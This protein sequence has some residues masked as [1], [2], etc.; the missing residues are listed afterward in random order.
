[1]IKINGHEIVIT[2]AVFDSDCFAEELEGY[3][4]DCKEMKLTEDDILYIS[5]NYTDEEIFKEYYKGD[6]PAEIKY[7]KPLLGLM[8][9]RIH[10]ELRIDEI[11]EAIKRYIS[12][13]KEIPIEWIEECGSLLSKKH[14][15]NIKEYAEMIGKKIHITAN[16]E[17]VMR[18]YHDGT[19]SGMTGIF[20][21]KFEDCEIKEKESKLKQLLPSWNL[22]GRGYTEKEALNDYT[23][24][25]IGK[26]LVFNAT[27]KYREEYYVKDLSLIE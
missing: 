13:K 24:N 22:Y 18:V 25:I 2:R 5:D 19:T 21:A 8:P 6:I 27:S 7:K 23:K 1:M 11:S 9:K 14:I 16:H 15:P 12:E 17:F 4:K 26:T 3:Y 10:D 20:V